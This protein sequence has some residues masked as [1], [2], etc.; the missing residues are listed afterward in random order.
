MGAHWAWLGFAD[1][2]ALVAEAR[3]NAAG[4]A[5]LIARYI[6]KAG[7]SAAI[8]G[9]DWEVF[10][11]GYNGP[12]YK[13]FS[14]HV[15]LA[16]A[17]QRHSGTGAGARQDKT[18]AGT[19]ATLQTGSTGDEVRDLQQTLSALGYPLEADGIFGRGTE[20]AV[21]A[22]QSDHGLP[23]DGIVG[24]IT[25]GAIAKA[26]PFGPPSDGFWSSLLHWITGLFRS[27]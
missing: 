19:P 8:H 9:H 10:A 6:E 14:Y 15:K 22:F 16:A 24:P 21:R 18:D 1:V 4:Q 13:R 17:Y 26:M 7:L 25:L 23:A 5:R 12:G 11:R 3:S 2:D 27:G 20:H